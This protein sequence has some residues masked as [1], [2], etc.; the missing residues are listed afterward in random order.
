MATRHR[1]VSLRTESITRSRRRAAP[2]MFGLCFLSWWDRRLRHQGAGRLEALEAN[3][4][5]LPAGGERHAPGLPAIIV[6][7]RLRP[8]GAPSVEGFDHQEILGN[9]LRLRAGRQQRCGQQKDR[10][11]RQAPPKRSGRQIEENPTRITKFHGEAKTLWP[12]QQV[13]GFLLSAKPYP[14]TAKRR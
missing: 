7:R 13:P 12:A 14:A 11:H 6:G 10:S 4:V 1:R 3:V 8:G 5:P 9:R 2:L